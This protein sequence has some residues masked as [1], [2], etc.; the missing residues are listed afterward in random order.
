M[1]R[2]S[3][4]P[5]HIRIVTCVN[6]EF[7]ASVIVNQQNSNVCANAPNGQRIYVIKERQIAN[8]HET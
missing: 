5:V 1:I 7:K 8:H 6:F 4:I 3:N 2:C